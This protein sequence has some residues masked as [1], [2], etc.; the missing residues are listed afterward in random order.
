MVLLLSGGIDSSALLAI[1][2][3]SVKLCLSLNYG[4][5]HRKELECAAWQAEHFGLPHRVLAVGNIFEDI[6]TPLLGTGV[7]PDKSYAEQLDEKEGT[8]T[9]YVPNRNMILLAIA[10]AHAIEF[11]CTTVAYAA[12]MDDADRGAYPDCTPEF[13]DKMDE[14]LR[15]QGITL[16]APFLDMR[17]VKAD[18]IRT[19]LRAGARFD[20]TWSC[21]K[22][23]DKP[24]G[25]CGTC[26]DRAAA[27]ES[28]HMG[29]PAII[30]YEE[31][32]F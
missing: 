15:T 26:R 24:C 13:K 23:G 32:P 5:L 9:T 11:G 16:Y 28:L 29:D 1:K 2:K 14:V 4:Q 27:F 20:H 18:V 31:V 19:G 30:P 22:G 25:T 3:K 7:I 10:A 8:V 17:M 21:Y 12:H 6:K